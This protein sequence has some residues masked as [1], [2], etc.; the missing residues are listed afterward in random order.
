MPNKS[1]ID[2]A[3]PGTNDTN[4]EIERMFEGSSDSE[5]EFHGSNVKKYTALT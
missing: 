1:G 4:S 5:D 2:I 3:E